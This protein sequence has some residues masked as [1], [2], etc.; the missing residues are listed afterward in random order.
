MEMGY[1]GVCSVEIGGME[2]CVGE[3]RGLV[4]GRGRRRYWGG[5]WVDF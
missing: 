2:G 4:G 3:E 1:W 5:E